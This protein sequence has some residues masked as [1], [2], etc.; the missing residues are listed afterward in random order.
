MDVEREADT[1][2]PSDNENEVRWTLNAPDYPPQEIE[3]RGDRIALDLWYP[4]NDDR[5][6]EIEVGLTD[7]RAADSIRISYDFERDGWVI[8]QASTF[9]WG[10][11]DDV[12]DEDWQ[13][14]A[15]VQAW[16]RMKE[17]ER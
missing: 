3:R 1:M 12:C 4:R 7:V 6:K 5:A 2:T 10:A 14:V 16:G 9:E 13:E 15:F 17:F 8:K 11:D